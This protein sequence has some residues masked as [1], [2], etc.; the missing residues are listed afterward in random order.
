[1]EAYITVYSSK[2][3]EWSQ[4]HQYDNTYN[5]NC[6]VRKASYI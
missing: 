3:L 4:G 6:I 5:D 1:M 2:T